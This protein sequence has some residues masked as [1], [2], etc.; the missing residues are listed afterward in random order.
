[1]DHDYRIQI[2][3][4]RMGKF[5]FERWCNQCDRMDKP[6]AD[7]DAILELNGADED[8]V[9]H[10]VV[11]ARNAQEAK[12]I[13]VRYADA[14]DISLSSSEISVVPKFWIQYL[15]ANGQWS[16]PGEGDCSFDTRAEADEAIDSLA[17]IDGYTDDEIADWRIEKSEDCPSN[18]ASFAEQQTAR[19]F[20]SAE[21][22]TENER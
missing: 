13:A 12:M 9:D 21:M 4:T 11:R 6:V 17:Q 2:D 1:M 10:W 19:E 7:D 15:D 16:F 14:C 22:G 20:Y 8:T 3:C 5:K 18:N